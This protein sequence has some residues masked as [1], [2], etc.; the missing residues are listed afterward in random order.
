MSCS[1]RWVGALRHGARGHSLTWQTGAH[2][3][4]WIRVFTTQA[5]LPAATDRRLVCCFFL[6]QSYVHGCAVAQRVVLQ[7]VFLKQLTT[8]SAVAPVCGSCSC[9]G[10]WSAVFDYKH[11]ATLRYCCCCCCCTLCTTTRV[12]HCPE[13]RCNNCSHVFGGR[14]PNAHLSSV[15]AST[16]LCVT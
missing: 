8:K 6:E 4:G 2:S 5:P 11:P 1:P 16:C 7:I 13:Y 10:P 15:V 3:T 14:V 12:G 9:S